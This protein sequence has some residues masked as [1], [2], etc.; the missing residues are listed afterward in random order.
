M[1][2]RDPYF[3]H[4]R[5]LLET[6]YKGGYID[7]ESLH[8]VHAGMHGLRLP[9]RLSNYLFVLIGS[10]SSY[11]EKYPPVERSFVCGSCVYDRK[12]FPQERSIQ[13]GEFLLLVFDN[14]GDKESGE[15]IHYAK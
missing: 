12:A 9:G 2:W 14:F 11:P 13:D 7:F 10:S 3:R 1:Q 8:E 5:I 4:G 15:G 6:R